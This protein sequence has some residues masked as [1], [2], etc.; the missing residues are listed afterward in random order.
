[1]TLHDPAS[2]L[3]GGGRN[4]LRQLA[5]RGTGPLLV[6]GPGTFAEPAADADAALAAG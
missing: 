6:I 2:V 3:A 1:M 5:E 4:V